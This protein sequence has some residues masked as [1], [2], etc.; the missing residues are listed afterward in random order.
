VKACLALACVFAATAQ[1]D[2]LTLWHAYRGGEEQALEQATKAFTA[3]T[4]HTVTLLAVPYDAFS[5]KLSSAIPHGA[6]PDVFIF[7]HERVRQFVRLDMLATS[8]GKL[9]PSVYLPAAIDALEVDGQSYG[10]PLSLKCLALYVNDALVTKAP[11]TTA[12]FLAMAPRLSAADRNQFALAYEAGDFYYHAPIL[13]GFQAPLFDAQGKASFDSP[14]MTHSLQFVRGLQDKGFMPQESSSALVKSLFNDGQAAMVISGPWFAGE[15]AEGLRYSVHPLPVVSETQEPMHPF[16]GVEAAFVSARSTKAAAANALAEFLARGEGARLRVTV[17][18]QIPAETAAYERPEVAQDTFIQSFHR[19][20]A[21]ARPTPNTLEMARL[22]EPMKLTLRAV[23]QGTAAAEDGGAVA[24]RRYRALNREA[25][26]ETSPVPWLLALG[27]AVVGFVLWQS[28]KKKEKAPDLKKA[29]VWVAPA[30]VGVLVLVLIPFVVGLSLSV[31]HHDAGHY[32]FVGSANFT[33][34]LTSKGYRVTEPLSFWFTLAVTV[35]WTAVNVFLHVAVGL[36]LALALK[37]PLLKLRGL[38]RVL[39]IVPWAVPNYITALMWKGLFHRQFG[40]ING[41]LH[42]LGVEPV[43]W[44]THFSTSFA[45]NVCTNTWLGFPF[46][47]VVALGALQAIPQDLY[48]AAEVDGASKWTQFTRITLPLLKPAMLPA[49][50]L[51]TVWTFNMFNVIYLVSGGDPGGATDILVSEAFRW[52]FQRNE[53]YGFA[54]AY[55][56]LIFVVLLGWSAITKRLGA[57]KTA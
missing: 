21:N 33:D 34:I 24:A 42:L 30:A 6:G 54:A 10:Y 22:W 29:I 40:A 25:P 5:A 23:L 50:V 45:A 28:R 47:M 52:A 17:G 57:E 35:L 16:L 3:Q 39:L 4:G 55:S 2:E 32:T 12:E 53:Q 15:I 44:F 26:P 11:D 36:A 46:M 7:A 38:F 37:S 43:S 13:L 31:F 1:A 56:V 51:G 19:A 20:A 27:A 14:G 48:E 41:L 18:R 49:V 9:D 8:T